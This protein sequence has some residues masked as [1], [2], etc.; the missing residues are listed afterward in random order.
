MF[1]IS[2]TDQYGKAITSLTQWDTN[3]ILYVEDWEYSTPTFHFS[4]KSKSKMLAVDGE[5]VGRTLKVRIPNALLT[6][7]SPI[8]AYVYIHDEENDSGRTISIIRIPVRK[9]PQPEEY[10]VVRET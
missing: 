6:E 5:L 2:C 3:Q 7:A 8:T 9:R 4:N 10:E 1:E